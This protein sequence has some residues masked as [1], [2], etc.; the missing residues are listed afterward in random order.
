MNCPDCNAKCKAHGKDRK[1][2]QR[3]SPVEIHNQKPDTGVEDSCGFGCVLAYF[4]KMGR[5]GGKIGGATRAANMTHEQ[6]SEGARKASQARWARV[7]A[8]RGDGA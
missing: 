7:K 5:K 4:V 8:E 3:Y 1:G 6:R 2:N